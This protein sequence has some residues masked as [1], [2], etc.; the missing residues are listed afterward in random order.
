MLGVKVTQQDDLISLYQQHFCESLLDLYGMRDCCPVCTPLIPNQ[1]LSSASE[2]ELSSFNALGISYQ[3]AIGSI[4]YLSTATRP[5]LSYAV[6]SLSQFLERPG[7]NHWKAVLHVLRYLRGTQDLALT[8]YK[9]NNSGIIAYSDADWG[10]CPDTR[11]SITWFLATFSG[12]L[13]IWKTRKQPTVSLSPSEEDYKSLCDLTSELLWMRQWCKEASLYG[14][15]MAI[16]IHEDNQGC[17]DA[18]RVN[19]GINGK[20]IKHVDIQL[21]FV[22]EAIGSSKTRLVYTTTGE[23]SKEPVDVCE[24][25]IGQ[26]S[27][28]ASRNKWNKQSFEEINLITSGINQRVFLE[29]VRPET[30]EKADLLW[31]SINEHYASKRNMNKGRVWMNWQKLNYTRNLQLYIDNTQKFLLDLQYVNVKLPPEILSYMILGKLGND[32]SLTQVVE[33]IT[34]ND[35]LLEKPNQVLL[36]LQEYANLQ[37]AKVTS[38][39]SPSVSALISSSDHKFKIVHFCSNGL[40]NPKCTTHRKD[41]CYAENPHLRPP[42]RNNKRKAQ[43]PL[44]SA[45]IATAH[46]LVTSTISPQSHPNQVVIDCG[47]PIT[48]SIQE[49]SSPHYLKQPVFTFRLLCGNQ[50]TIT[51][52]SDSFDLTTSEKTSLHGKIINNLM[53]VEFIQPKSLVTTVVDDLWHKR[54][55]HPGKAPVRAMGL[56]SHNLPCHTCDLNKI[57]QLPFKDQFEHFTRMLKHKSEAFDCFLNVKNLME[58]QHD[59]RIKNL[60]SD[61]GGEFLNERFKRLALESGFIHTFSPSYTPQHNGFAERANRTILDKAKCLLNGCGLPKQFWAEAINT[62]TFLCNLIPTPSRHNKSPYALWTGKSPRIKKL[63]VFGCQAVVLIH[64]NFRDWKLGESGCKGIFLGYEND[65]SSYRVMRIGD[66][67]V[68]ISKHVLFDESIYPSSPNQFS[69]SSPLVI[70]F[71]KGKEGSEI[72]DDEVQTG[73]G[74]E[75]EAEEPHQGDSAHIH[76]DQEVEG[77]D[78]VP[79]IPPVDTTKGS[80]SVARPK[81]RVIGPRHPTLISSN[82]DQSN[83]LPYSRR[84]GA[85]L[86]SVEVAPRTFKMAINSASKEVWL[87]AIA[88]ELT[89]MDTLKVWDIVELDPSFKLVGMTWVF[90]IKKDHLGNVTEHKA[91]L[92]AQGFSQTAGVDFEKTYSPT[93]RLNSLRTLIAFAAR[94]DLLFHQIDIKSAF[95]NAPLTDVNFSPCILDPCVFYQSGDS[96]LRL[97]VHVDDIAIFGKD[98][99]PFKAEISREFDVKDIGSADLM[100]GVKVTQQDDLIS[101][102]QQHFCESLLDLYGMGDCRPVCTSLIPNPHLSSASEEELSSFNALGISYR[103]AIGSIN[104]LSTATRPDLSYAV[105]SLSQFLERPGINHWKAFLHVLRYLRGTQDLA[106]TYY[107]G[108]NSGIVAYSD[109]DWGNCP[110][111]RRSITGFLAMFSGCLVIWKTRKQPT[112]SLSTSEAEYKSLCDLTSELLWMRQWCKEASLYDEDTAIPIHEDN[113]GCIDAASGNSGISGKR[114]KHVDIQLHFVREAIGSSKTR[115]VYTPTGEMLANFLTKSVSRV[116]LGK[117]LGSLKVLRLIARGDVRNNNISV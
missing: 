104:Y 110:D 70:P 8:Y 18:A 85:L 42:R 29:V 60:V 12:C 80:Q 66:G 47:A 109:A 77:V 9:G 5:D 83:I 91:R 57:H 39:D 14:E 26:D 52:D 23:M 98:V 113:Q 55:G 33:M 76:P 87:E 20:R 1:H 17:I 107:K 10:N 84:A 78:E 102:D 36:R 7:I 49:K 65:M 48:C 88:K 46:A 112:V 97:Y 45:H 27:T 37:T 40:H 44:A 115:L 69:S 72:S 105:S 111:T 114:M 86:T 22:R 58:N 94:N 108:D 13:V 34:Y 81:L 51:R 3:S 62:A 61:R 116:T 95:L 106:L 54:L 56:P 82:I 11:R 2:E 101:L 71:T 93:G 28:P 74:I 103:S 53:K 75:E 21:H 43:E 59:R 16:P 68:L 100:L 31:T 63:R 25:P 99:E 50:I 19:S 73:V 15:D 90:K 24:N 35:N 79:S 38:K 96:P 64:C 92:C 6:S 89:S 117:A 4:N 67:K 41:Q 30:S 32:S